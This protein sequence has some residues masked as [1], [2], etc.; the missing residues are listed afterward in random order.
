MDDKSELLNRLRI[1]REPRST[2]AG[3]RRLPWIGGGLAL[4]LVTGAGLWWLRAPSGIP[5]Q[6]V[7][8]QPVAGGE[9]VG[10]SVLDASGYVVARRQ[11]TVS[12][13]ITGRL[14]EL[15]IE[16][17]EHVK[18]GQVIARLDPSNARAALDQARAQL[19]ESTDALQSIRVQMVNAGRD[20]RRN[21]TLAAQHLVSQSV[22]D[23][24]RSTYEQLQA[25]LTTAEATVQVSR[26]GVEVAQRALDDT[27]VRAPFAGVITD[28]AAQPGEIVSPISAGGGFTRTGIGTLVDMESLEIEVDVNE[29]F[30]NRVEPEQK[31]VARLNAYPDWNIPAHVIAVVPTADRSKGTVKVRIG[32]DRKTGAPLDA[33]ILPEM[34]V[35]V[36][37]LAAAGTGNQ[38]GPSG[39]EVP[40]AA[41]LGGGDQGSV[42][43]I[44]GDRVERRAV[45]LGARDGDQ[46]QVLAGVPAGT[47]LAAG[48]LSKLSDGSRVRI[49]E[50]NP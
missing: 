46:V 43:V 48:D 22:L 14:S 27:V 12:A 42:F 33:R 45:R 20:Y 49:K 7:T 25:Q 6:A 38:P 10:G 47:R 23:N 34:G 4:L 9:S 8:A 32:F 2:A 24:S 37:F 31:V 44:H 30:I 26:A 1:E 28:K 41:V 16:E 17:G 39:V 40:A 29:N 15:F 21:R 13:K 18:E 36:S 5:V 50:S 11:A 3:R 35:R 19:K